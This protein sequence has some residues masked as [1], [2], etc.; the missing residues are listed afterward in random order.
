MRRGQSPSRREF[1]KVNFQHRGLAFVKRL[2]FRLLPLVLASCF[3][4]AA[5]DK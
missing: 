4:M 2:A 3:G 5:Y 1:L